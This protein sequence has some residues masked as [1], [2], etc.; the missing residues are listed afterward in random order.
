[1][2]TNT[3]GAS[4][5]PEPDQPVISLMLSLGYDAEKVRDPKREGHENAYELY[6]R[7]KP[8]RTRS[9]VAASLPEGV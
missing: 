8:D 1:M 3:V 4:A 7:L 2:F 9:A 6:E 5:V